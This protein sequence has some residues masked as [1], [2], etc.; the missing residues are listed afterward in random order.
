M[1]GFRT[2]AA[3]VMRADSRT[4]LLAADGVLDI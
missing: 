2:A 4:W 3:A 1:P